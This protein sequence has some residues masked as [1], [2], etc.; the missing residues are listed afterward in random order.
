MFG[1]DQ[2]T[3]VRSRLP[4]RPRQ[5]S[6]TKSSGKIKDNMVIAWHPP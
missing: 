1:Q 6:K 5:N 3:W 2:D 4:V